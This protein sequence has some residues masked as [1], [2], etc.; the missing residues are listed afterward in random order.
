M[1]VDRENEFHTECRYLCQRKIYRATE[2]FIYDAAKLVRTE[3]DKVT[4]EKLYIS[5]I[6]LLVK[7]Y[8]SQNILR[9]LYFFAKE[10]IYIRNEKK[11]GLSIIRDL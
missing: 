2:G 8:W 4:I 11:S 7:I 3:S 10:Q 5:S 6:L 9:V 1:V